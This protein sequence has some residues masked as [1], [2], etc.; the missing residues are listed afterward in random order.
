[1]ASPQGSRAL[2]VLAVLGTGVVLAVFC[3]RAR[4]ATRAPAGSTAPVAPPSTPPSLLEGLAPGDRLGDWTVE[5]ILPARGPG[6]RPELAVELARTDGGRSVGITVWV[7]RKE[8]AVK[9]PVVTD[10]YALSYGHARPDGVSVTDAEFLRVVALVAE[11]IRRTE[12]VAPV[13]SG[14]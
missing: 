2:R 7:Q 1:M 14:L 5:R 9:P 10:R 3:A 11:R 4:V 8:D 13:P 6:D 12:A